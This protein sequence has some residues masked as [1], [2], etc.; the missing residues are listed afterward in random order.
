MGLF[1][2]GRQVQGPGVHF[3]ETNFAGFMQLLLDGV[4]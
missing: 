2:T 4:F 1:D 3:T